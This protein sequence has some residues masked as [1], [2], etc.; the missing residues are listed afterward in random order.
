MTS[1]LLLALL[2]RLRTK[3]GGGTCPRSLQIQSCS[4]ETPARRVARAVPGF[5]RGQG[6]DELSL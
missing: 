4:T 1:K 5:P 6:V 2:G 3:E